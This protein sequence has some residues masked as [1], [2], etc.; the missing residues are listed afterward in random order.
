MDG[1]GIHHVEGVLE[2]ISRSDA[3]VSS[4]RAGDRDSSGHVL[5]HPVEASVRLSGALAL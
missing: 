4:A 3:R 5:P 2:M 1:R